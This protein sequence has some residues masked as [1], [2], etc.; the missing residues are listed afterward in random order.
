M[1][2]LIFL[3]VLLN[4]T[5]IPLFSQVKVMSYNIRLDAKS[6][7]LDNWH[8]RKADLVCYLDKI[9]ADFLG[10]QEG[11]PG[12]VEYLDKMLESYSFIGDGREGPGKGEYSAIFFN[13]QKWKTKD[14]GMFWLS[15]TPEKVTMGWDAACHRVCTYGVFEDDS[16]SRVAVYNTHFDHVG[17]KAREESAALIIKRINKII[18]RYPVVL[19][20]DFNVEPSNYVYDVLTGSLTDTGK[21]FST[22]CKRSG[23]FNGFKLDGFNDR[24]IDYIFINDSLDISSY[25]IDKPLTKKGRQL[26]DHFPVIGELKFKK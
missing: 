24:R 8:K 3:I 6:D 20:G 9:N 19:M 1:R 10:I 2:R 23:T 12:Q 11:M 14:S 16:G 4:L 22:F 25:R 18:G 21:S 15:E 17:Q 26:S 7:G 5:A 13:H